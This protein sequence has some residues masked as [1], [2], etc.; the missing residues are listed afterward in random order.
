MNTRK[1]IS[2][3]PAVFWTAVIATIVGGWMS[4]HAYQS[5]IHADDALVRSIG[6]FVVLE[7]VSIFA[8]ATLNT[9]GHGLLTGLA[10]V[11][12][13]GCATT[14]IFLGAS[15]L[16]RGIMQ[17][18]ETAKAASASTANDTANASALATA[19]EALKACQARYPRKKKD[20]QARTACAKPYEKSI[21][22]LTAGDPA[23]AVNF[24]PEAAGML[25]L[26]QGITDAYNAMLDKK[27]EEAAQ[28]E[29]V[30]FI[31]M[32]SIFT[33]FVVGKLFMWSRYAAW[34]AANYG[35]DY[36]APNVVTVPEHA[37]GNSASVADADKQAESEPQSAKVPFGFTGNKSPATSSAE[38]NRALYSSTPVTTGNCNKQV[39]VTTGNCNTGIQ[40][41]GYSTA[42]AT[43]QLAKVGHVVD[44][45]VCGK[46]FVKANKWHTF[47]SNNRKP[48][49]DGGNCSDD[50]HNATDPQR[51]DALKAL[52]RRKT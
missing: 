11:L 44:C 16:Q 34:K 20:A 4:V 41:S 45:P 39:S 17:M 43:V 26:W 15:E 38:R 51:L 29:R 9:R 32:L 21:T 30:A 35:D 47:C 1:R 6:M 25:A 13:F 14:E 24:D 23:K 22:A 8:A 50:Y 2:D 37:I 46:T 12:I 10:F 52:K 36:Q 33:V 19:Q 5:M 3:Y 27:G 18:T 49:P 7:S 48:R 42:Y 31:A 40:N 28:V